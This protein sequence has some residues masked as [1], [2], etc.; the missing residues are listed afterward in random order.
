M[1]VVNFAKQNTVINQYIAE[2]RD[3]NI[4]KDRAR[5]R[6]NLARIGQMIAYEVSKTLKYSEKI[7][8]TPLA[9]AK[10][11]VPADEVVLATIFRAGLPFHQ[12]F[13]DIFDHADNGFVSAYRYY[14]D[15]ECKTVDVKV[16]YIASPDLTNKVLLIADPMLATGA[17]FELGYH[18]FIT[19]GKPATV[20]LCCAI[21]SQKGVDNIKKSFGSYENVTLWCGAIDPGLDERSY[22][23]PGLGDCGDLAYGSK[24]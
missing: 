24:L 17:S 16:E 11:S 4:Q 7:V 22:I 14:R 15:K 23:V 2:L 12:G 9:E 6:H 18:A 19:N 3:V 5:F 1:K 8:Q 21:A 20:H 13:L 10:V